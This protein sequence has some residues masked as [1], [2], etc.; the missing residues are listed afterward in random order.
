ML[1]NELKQLF[2]PAEIPFV[3]VNPIIE[4]LTTGIKDAATKG[5]KRFLKSFR[6]QPGLGHHIH[7]VKK[8]FENEGLKINILQP[9][10]EFTTYWPIILEWE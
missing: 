3:D 5:Q 6:N 4:S 2:K 9:D 7:K 10:F 8:H 1:L